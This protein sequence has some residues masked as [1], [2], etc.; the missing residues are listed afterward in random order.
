MKIPVIGSKIEVTTRYPSICLYST[1][2]YQDNTYVGTVI[3]NDRWVDAN[4]FSVMTGNKN[5]PVSVI[6]LARVHKLKIIE[7]S[8]INV[9]TYKVK[10]YIVTQNG[11]HFSCTCIGFKYHSKCRHI[12]GVKD[13]QVKAA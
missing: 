11:D 8:S 12:T 1:K 13:E 9:K 6:N 2:K 7:G 5:H 4:S 10:D 3:K